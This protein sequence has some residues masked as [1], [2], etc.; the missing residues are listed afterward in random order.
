[1]QEC[2]AAVSAGCADAL[3]F[4]L[5]AGMMLMTT[6]MTIKLIQKVSVCYCE[7]HQQ[8]KQLGK[9]SRMK[10]SVL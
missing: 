10:C 1:M 3:V 4:V 8:L 7:L 9:L 2:N 6:M 5:V